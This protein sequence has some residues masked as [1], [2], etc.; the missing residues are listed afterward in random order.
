MKWQYRTIVGCLV[1]VGFVSFASFARA[2]DIDDAIEKVEQ[3][4][5]D[6]MKLQS[7]STKGFSPEMTPEEQTAI[8]KKA[9]E[10]HSEQ[11]SPKIAEILEILRPFAAE[12]KA[13]DGLSWILSND[14]A[15]PAAN[16]AA[17]LLVEHHLN[18]PIVLQSA[19]R[20]QYAPMRWTVP[21]LEK[22]VASN[23]PEDDK[24]Q[25][26]LYLAQTLKTL[27]TFPALVANLSDENL[28]MI[29]SRYGKDYLEQMMNADSAALEQ[30]A[31]DLYTTLVDEF[32][33]KRV[34][35]RTVKE[36]V[37]SAIFEIE[38]LTIGKTAPEIAGEDVDGVEFKLS[39]YRGKV[40]MLDFW[41]DW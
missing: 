28:M 32:G 2:D 30:R 35:G 39:D 18:H 3:I 17:N 21:M 26:T 16:G 11:I 19:S 24:M 37:D 1:A 33:D 6:V 29:E 36:L 38:N 10:I 20:F 15:S 7:A 5:A 4:K 8:M 14:S 23:P 31:V 25:A 34:Y 27:S 12:E 13:V 9:M 41:G 40:V 22:I